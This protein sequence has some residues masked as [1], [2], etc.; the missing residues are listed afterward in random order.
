MKYLKLMKGMLLILSA[1]NTNIIE[2][3]VD[4]EFSVHPYF[5]SHNVTTMKIGQGAVISIS[6]KQKLNTKSSNKA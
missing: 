1:E 4:Y 3:Y 6:K 5:N 2:W